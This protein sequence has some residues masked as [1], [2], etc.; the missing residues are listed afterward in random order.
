MLLIHKD[1]LPKMKMTYLYYD[2]PELKLE[3]I[4]YRNNEDLLFIY[5]SFCPHFG[6]KLE[7]KDNELYC[8][9]HG[10]R[11]D[12]DSGKCKNREVGINCKK[13][14]YFET[15]NGIEIVLL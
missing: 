6:G 13:Y 8:Y 3:F 1:N 12:L 4:I 10:Y 14:N 9:F 11:Y 7:V 5:S 15:D 2:F